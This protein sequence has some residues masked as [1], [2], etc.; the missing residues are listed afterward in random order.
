MKK[1]IVIVISF[2]YAALMFASDGF[3]SNDELPDGLKILPP[4]PSMD[5][6]A[7]GNWSPAFGED[8][9]ISKTTFVNENFF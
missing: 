9:V 6:D 2:F 8:Q 1:I 3:L 4:P 7:G 5:K